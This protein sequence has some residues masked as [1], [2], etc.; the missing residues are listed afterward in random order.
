MKE[1]VTVSVGFFM[2]M[3]AAVFVAF[4]PRSKPCHACRGRGTVYGS[5]MECLYC[6][7]TGK[8]T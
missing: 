1:Y 2:F 5:K 8:R 7:G 3:V 6:D 4:V